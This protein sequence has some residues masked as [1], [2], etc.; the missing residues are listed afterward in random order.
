[1]KRRILR[2]VVFAAALV[3]IGALPVR[4]VAQQQS[5]QQG[6]QENKKLRYRLVDIGTFGGPSSTVPGPNFGPSGTAKSVNN[7]GTVAGSGDTP[8]PDPDGFFNGD[9][10]VAHA[11]AWQDGVT[12]DLGALGAVPSNNVSNA[13]WISETGLIA[14]V[15]E[16]GVIDPL[17]PGFPEIRAV[18]WK[19]GQ[20]ID[21]G[22]LG[23]NESFAN[24][25]NNRGQVIGWALN[26]ILDPFFIGTEARP[27][28]WQDGVMHDL[29]DLGGHDAI[30]IFVN[31]RG[32][33][34]GAS[35][36]NSTPLPPVSGPIHP[37][38]IWRKRNLG[39]HWLFS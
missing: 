23:G 33:V 1:M 13:T 5:E 37:A 25:V 8:T 32:Q 29:G 38:R 14:G 22:T 30:A 18:L 2:A 4:L 20:I 31:E 34:A 26:S 39:H 15:S 24:A 9:F 35:L 3:L 7:P 11:F 36:I 16:N 21:L 12:T 10:F 17:V 27:F 6:L 28:L 19:D